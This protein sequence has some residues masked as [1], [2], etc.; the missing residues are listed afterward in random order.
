M[1]R[2]QAEYRK[3]LIAHTYLPS[4]EVEKIP[5][6]LEVLGVKDY[7]LDNIIEQ[8]V[9]KIKNDSHERA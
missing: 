1:C 3:K 7:N 5:T 4:F 6:M 9:K 2:L 8:R